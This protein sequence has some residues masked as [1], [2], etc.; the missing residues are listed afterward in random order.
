MHAVRIEFNLSKMNFR[1]THDVVWCG[2]ELSKDMKLYIC[3]LLI[4]LFVGVGVSETKFWFTHDWSGIQVIKTMPT[5]FHV[6]VCVCVTKHHAKNRILSKS[7]QI[8][9]LFLSRSTIF[10]DG[11]RNKLF[12]FEVQQSQRKRVREREKKSYFFSRCDSQVANSLFTD[13][14]SHTCIQSRDGITNARANA[15][16]HI[17]HFRR[18]TSEKFRSATNLIKSWNIIYYMCVRE[19]EREKKTE[20]KGVHIAKKSLWSRMSVRVCVLIPM[21]LKRI[22]SMAFIGCSNQFASIHLDI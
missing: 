9:I 16:L 20:W 21:V 11:K 14:Q 7:T 13:S 6:S 3:C 1:W 8:N 2:V 10:I 15:K 12:D 22:V 19:R 17:L 18:K 5:R 4:C